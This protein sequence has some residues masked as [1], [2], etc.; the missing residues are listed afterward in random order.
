MKRAIVL[1]GG[2]SK[3]AY[4]IG[5][6]KAL[7]KLGISYDI[8][9][10]TSIG[11][12]NGAF[13]TMN[14]YPEAI[15][16]WY[17]VNY[18][19]I[20]D[21]DISDTYADPSGRRKIIKTYVKGA[22]TG[23]MSVVSMENTIEEYLDVDKFF[24]SPIDYG[25]VTVSFPSLK[26]ITMTK[27]DLTKENVKDYLIASAS[28]F[29]AFKIKQIDN[30]KF[31]D[32]G[33]YDNLPINLAIDMGAD[34]VI[35]VDLRAVGNVKSVKNKN[36]PITM[37]MPRN[38]IGNFLVIEKDYARRAMRF[39][40]ND[41]LKTY[42]KLE[43][44]LYTFKKGSLSRNYNR[45]GIKFQTL[46]N[47]YSNGLV[48]KIAFKKMLLENYEKDFNEVLENTAKA[49]D[50]DESKIYRTSVI[51]I[52]I[53]KKY[54]HSSDV[55]L[56]SIKKD[57]KNNKLGKNVVSKEL[58]LYIYNELNNNKRKSI[59]ELAQLFPKSFLS[60]LYLLTIER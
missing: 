23:G 14:D 56:A 12:L 42:G 40:Y 1:S 32:G 51:N 38:D 21:E 49:F 60:A 36:V 20:I 44:N 48:G 26:P 4:E 53:K 29:P 11:A 16:L 13:M 5:F 7:R 58:I 39:G 19:N 41:T 9:T 50:V 46:L 52:L 57:I 47:T 28:C 59:L 22:L 55:S 45:N 2:G 35:A 3:G 37:I 15:R 27:K 18:N 25:L 24:S 43:G 31:I 30:N 6:W 33:Y 54:S 17:F 8:V 10:G 34:E